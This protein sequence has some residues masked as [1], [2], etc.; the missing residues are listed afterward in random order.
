MHNCG[1]QGSVGALKQMGALEMGLDEHEL[2][3][4][5]AQWR[6]TNPSIVSFW[7][8]LEAKVKEVIKTRSRADLRG[9]EIDYHHGMLFIGLPS[10]RHLAYPKATI[11]PH[12]K[13]QTGEEI[14]YSE[15]DP[16][17]GWR[18]VPTYGGKLTENVVQAIARDALVEAMLAMDRAGHRIVMHVHDEVV[19]E[20]EADRAEEVLGEML[21]LM[22]LPLDWAPGLPLKAAGFTCDYYQKD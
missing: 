11:R 21:D 3:P 6:A 18:T 17:G 12:H 4:L 20:T 7:G 2:P 19:V 1:Y 16:K 22:A 14:A 15:I 9:L 5:V 10:G 13:F 8:E